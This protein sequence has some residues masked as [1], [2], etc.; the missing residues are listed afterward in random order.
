[1]T[2]TDFSVLLLAWDDADPSVAVLGGAAL[3]P[4]LPLVYH[5]AREQ[6]VLAVFPHLP[7]ELGTN[8]ENAPAA[9]GAATDT[10]GFVV[11]SADAANKDAE[12]EEATAT[13][14]AFD[15]EA[16]PNAA[17]GIRRLEAAG[18]AKPASASPS[19]LIGLA[20][21][22]TANTPTEL[23]AA[24]PAP[25]TPLAPAPIRSQWPTGANAPQ[26]LSWS[27][28]AAPYLGAS[29]PAGPPVVAPVPPLV[30]API[31]REAADLAQAALSWPAGF[32]PLASPVAAQVLAGTTA[33]PGTDAA[34]DTEMAEATEEAAATE[35]TND[36]AEE[37]QDYSTNLTP[38]AFE[39]ITEEIGAAEAND[40]AAPE[41]NLTPDPIE[42]TVP[43]AETAPEYTEA[44]AA[45]TPEPAPALTPR[46][47]PLDG[48]NSRMI[49]YARQAAQLVRD[50]ADFGVIYAPSWPAWL[51]A[52]EI[53][54]SSRRP[55]VLY[56]ARLAADFAQPAER[57]WLLEVERMALRRARLVLVPDEAVRRQ[58]RQHYGAD[59]GEVRVVPAADEAALQALLQEL[60]AG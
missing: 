24:L 44:T 21:L 29:A 39:E 59:T 25:T 30:P 35:E 54:N 18:A 46:T 34:E 58:L 32:S 17:A 5:L 26:H 55:L 9:P 16:F 38:E 41:D 43:A 7:E 22:A 10:T 15:N 28:P 31:V 19:F 49:Q 8:S 3:P 6:P 51:A 36:D 4:T 56:T 48:L 50:R 60:A 1:M 45:P 12:N 2:L 14:G 11:E 23:Q 27:A 37:N 57:G 33:T 42:E 40:L 53:R 47:P 52:L 20:Y 13:E